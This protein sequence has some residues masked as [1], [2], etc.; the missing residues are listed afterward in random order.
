MARADTYTLLPLDTYA[1]IMGLNPL[2]FNGARLP[3]VSPEP[4]T[5][6]GQN[7]AA[8]GSV[9]ADGRPIW[10]QYAWKDQGSISREELARIIRQAEEDIANFLG[11][12]PAPDWT[13]QEYHLYPRHHR[14]EVYQ[15]GINARGQLKS[16]KTRWGK[17]IQAGRRNTDLVGTPTVAGGGLV[18]SDPNSDGWN[19]LATITQA[20][21]VT[22]ECEIKLYY[23]NYSGAREW[24]IRPL[25][26]VS[27]SGGVATITVDSWLMFDEDVINAI[28]T[29]SVDSINAGTSGN[30]LQS[31]EVRRDY[32]DFTE[33]S[34][35]FFW[36]REAASTITDSLT[37]CTCLSCG[38]L[39]CE[40]CSLI[41]Q[42]G[43]F[44]IRNA[45][46]GMVAPI[47][48]TY[49]SDDARWEKDQWTEC[50]EPDAV[51]VWYYSGNYSERWLRGETC[52][53]LTSKFARLIAILATARIPYGEGHRN[54]T[55]I[56]AQ[57]EWYTRDLAESGGNVNTVFTPP[58]ILNNP[59]GTKRGEAEVYRS[60]HSLTPRKISVGATA[61]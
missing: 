56:S 14:V 42:N 44:S 43:C 5:S 21:T 15:R 45:E 12:W 53:P 54:V 6:R 57:L 9:L 55:P 51:K 13:A 8:G 24:E 46:S 27:I 33:A 4:F 11:Y 16:V 18:Y 61:A 17:V 47:P 20:T 32:T 36:E 37:D 38:G 30:Y 7:T 19:T 34:A 28:P 41:S 3:G 26:S 50:R 35:Q 29:A 31:V 1:Q 59:F 58:D 40:S 48:A 60:L 2:H 49:D 39:G 52:T 10:Q 25:R 22:N 23:P